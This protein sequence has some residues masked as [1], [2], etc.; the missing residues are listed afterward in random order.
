MT[1]NL[2]L[3]RKSPRSYALRFQKKE[4]VTGQKQK[5]IRQKMEFRLRGFRF[6]NS[7]K[8]LDERW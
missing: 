1:S 7:L 5:D 4:G 2:Q 3:L 6:Q 8:F